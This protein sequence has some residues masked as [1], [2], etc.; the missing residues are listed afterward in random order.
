MTSPAFEAFLARVYVDGE[1]RE[2]FLRDPYGEATGAG[3]SETESRALERIDRT[4][5]VMAARSYSAKRERKPR[6]IG[7]IRRIFAR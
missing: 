5:L 2:R 3:L 7:W 4:G 1:F 6:R